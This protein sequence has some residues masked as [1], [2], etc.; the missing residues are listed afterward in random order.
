M[1]SHRFVS[2][3]VLLIYGSTSFLDAA[4]RQPNVIVLFTHG[5]THFIE[6]NRGRPFFMYLAYHV[7]HAPYISTPN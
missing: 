3:C 7:P 6:K 5:A 1:S 2:L 4:E